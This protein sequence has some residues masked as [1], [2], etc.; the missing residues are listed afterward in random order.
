MMYRLPPV[1]GEWI[2]RWC[3]LSFE[4]EGRS[5]KGYAG[6]TIGSALAAAGEM[7]L[8]RSFK[9]HRPRGIFSFANHDAN[10]LFQVGGIPNV[11]G[12]VTALAA[13]MQVLAV[14]TVGG[15]ARDRARFLEWL[16][17]F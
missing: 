6:D 8:G 11:R 9:Y 4:F 14:N 16:A 1:P 5:L 13:G 2:D 12:D 10:N 15:V 17:P 3:E 7:T